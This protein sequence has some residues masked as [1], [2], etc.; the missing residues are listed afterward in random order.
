MILK[1][2]IPSDSSLHNHID[3]IDFEDCFSFDISNNSMWINDLYVAIFSSAPK[4]VEALMRFRNRIVR[5][6]GLKT[7]MKETPNSD[8]KVGDKVGIFS[9]YEILN[10]EIIAGEDDKHLNFRVSIHRE[11]KEKTTVS[12]ST[13]VLYNNNFGK[14]YMTIVKPFHKLV[15]KSLMKKACRKLR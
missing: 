4:W 7:E 1:S 3:N 14:V 10:N 12:V 6:F 5:V 15:V 9:I 8:F 2:D 11:I 13:A